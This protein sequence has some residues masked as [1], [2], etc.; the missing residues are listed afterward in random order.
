VELALLQVNYLS[1]QLDQQVLK[2]HQALQDRKDQ[3]EQQALKDQLV[4]PVL[5]VLKG[6][7]VQRGSQRGQEIRQSF[8][9]EM[10]HRS[11]WEAV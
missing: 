11:Q 5:R 2:D 7:P 9:Q 10:D 6:Q 3:R 1:P 8:L 4:P